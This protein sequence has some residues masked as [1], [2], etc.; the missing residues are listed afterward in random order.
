MIADLSA[1]KPTIAIL[2]D[3]ALSAGYLLASAARQIVMPETGW[4]GSIGV[5]TLHADMSAAL[6]KDG[7]RVTVL[8]SGAHKADGNP[9]APLPAP[10]ADKI[11]ADLAATRD[12]FAETVARH[13]GPRL[14]KAAALA[15]E[16]QVY[17]GPNA[18]AAGLADAVM[19]PSE[20]FA[21]F[22]DAVGTRGARLSAGR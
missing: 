9:F 3:Y 2:T 13:R 10:V 19:R 20:A 4:A 16:A 11:R 15:T 22:V 8:S 21:A 7:L 14:T 18:V 1:E 6:E 5:I 12:L 17:T